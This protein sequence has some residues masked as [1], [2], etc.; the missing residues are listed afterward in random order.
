MTAKSAIG[1]KGLIITRFDCWKFR[2]QTTPSPSCLSSKIVDT[3]IEILSSAVILSPSC[4]VTNLKRSC[5][6]TATKLRS[7]VL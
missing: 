1:P 3:Y 7:V 5:L 2:A 4:P 6:S